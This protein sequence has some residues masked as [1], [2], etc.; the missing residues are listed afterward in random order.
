MSGSLIPSFLVS[1]VSKLLRSLTKNELCEQIAQVA[2]KKWASMSE[3]LRSRLSESL[4]FWANRSFAHF[5]AKKGAIRLEN[6][7]ANSQPCIFLSFYIYLRNLH[8]VLL[9]RYFYYFI[10][11]SVSLILFLLY[12]TFSHSISICLICFTVLILYFFNF[13]YLY[14]C[15]VPLSLS[16]VYK[17]ISLSMSID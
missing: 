15:L 13:I 6:R 10:E 1:D 9:F 7:W 2:H 14:Q 11:L 8:T 3:S 17:S 16:H 12:S 5:W 4:V